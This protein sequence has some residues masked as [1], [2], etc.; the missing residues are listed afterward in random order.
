[1]DIA[2]GL[3]PIELLP[4]TVPVNDPAAVGMQV[5]VPFVALNVMPAGSAPVVIANVYTGAVLVTAAPL[6][7]IGAV[8]LLTPFVKV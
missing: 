6:F 2:A 7:T 8:V 5:N 1:M 4:V 3:L